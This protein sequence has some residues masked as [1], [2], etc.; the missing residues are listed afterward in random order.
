MGN[1]EIPNPEIPDNESGNT[2]IIPESDPWKQIRELDGNQR[3]E[4]SATTGFENLTDKQF[5]KQ[6]DREHI[7]K[8][9]QYK[10]SVKSLK[11]KIQSGEFSGND[12]VGAEE[13]IKTMEKYLDEETERLA[14]IIEEAKK[15]GLLK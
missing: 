2:N 12:L 1:P 10:E 6:L 7:M 15:R 5:G 3:S 8:M 4:K 13:Q 14:P 11:L 9:G